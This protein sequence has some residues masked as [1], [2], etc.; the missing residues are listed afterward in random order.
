[1]PTV[2]GKLHDSDGV[3]IPI[4]GLSFTRI[5]TSHVNNRTCLKIHVHVLT[6]HPQKVIKPDL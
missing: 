6:V 4:L 1:M 2:K 5:G 3:C